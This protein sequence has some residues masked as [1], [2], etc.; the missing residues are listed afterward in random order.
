MTTRKVAVLGGTGYVGQRVCASLLA[1]GNEVVSL[2]RS[3]ALKES[4]QKPGLTYESA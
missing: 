2:S 3:G 4:L 1:L